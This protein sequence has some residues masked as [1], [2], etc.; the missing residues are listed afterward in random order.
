M[1]FHAFR[2]ADAASFPNRLTRFLKNLAILDSMLLVIQHKSAGV[3][4]KAVKL[5]RAVV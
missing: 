5:V 4:R 1:V 2:N 3:T